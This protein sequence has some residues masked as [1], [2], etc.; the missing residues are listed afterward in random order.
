MHI[1]LDSLNVFSN[2]NLNVILQ[3]II[4]FKYKCVK[5]LKNAYLITLK[6]DF[7]KTVLL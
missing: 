5:S 1:F 3:E 6:D 7:I 4:S 2:V